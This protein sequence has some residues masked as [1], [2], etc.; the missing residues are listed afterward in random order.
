M[1][2]IHPKPIP[3]LDSTTVEHLIACAC[4]YAS[5]TLCGVDSNNSLYLNRIRISRA[6]GALNAVSQF[7]V[8]NPHW[9]ELRKKCNDL[10][11]VGIDYRDWDRD[12]PYD[13][14]HPGHPSNY[15]D[16]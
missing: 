16:N 11:E 6:I 2:I 12:D 7:V 14:W 10:W 5:G 13:D 3:P 15:G 4:A 8:V 9:D 1:Q